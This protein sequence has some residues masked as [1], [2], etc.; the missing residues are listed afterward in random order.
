MTDKV[1]CESEIEGY[2]RLGQNCNRWHAGDGCER[3]KKH[4]SIN[5]GLLL[6]SGVYVVR[7]SIAGSAQQ[8]AC[9]GCHFDAI[10]DTSS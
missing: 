7:K 10:F 6:G 4:G 1:A 2:T 3:Y 8:V 5:M 9:V